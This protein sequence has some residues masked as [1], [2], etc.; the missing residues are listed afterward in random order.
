[1]KWIISFM[2]MILF[3]YGIT[4][5][6]LRADMFYG[7]QDPSQPKFGRVIDFDDREEGAVSEDDYAAQ[8]I[9]SI[10]ETELLAGADFGYYEEAKFSK[11]MCVGTGEFSERG[12]G[13]SKGWDG[14]ILIQ[15]KE[16]AS[17]VGVGIVDIDGG[18][19]TIAVYTNHDD[20][21]GENPLEIYEVPDKSRVYVVIDRL[22]T[23]DIKYLQISGDGFTIDDLQFDVYPSIAGGMRALGDVPE[24]PVTGEVYFDTVYS[25]A[26]IFN[27]MNWDEFRGPQGIQGPIGP[28]G[29]D[30]SPDTPAQVLAKISQVDG[31]GSGLDA[32]TLDG[33]DSES[34]ASSS[35]MHDDRYYTE[36]ELNTVNGGGQVNWNN[37]TD[38]PA[39]FADNTDDIGVETETD[40]VY[41]NSAASG[42][43]T[44][45]ISEWDT[46][47]GWGDHA[48]VGYLTEE[49]WMKSGSDIYY[50]DGNVGIRTNSPDS[51]LDVAGVITANTN[52]ADVAPGVG[53]TAA[54]FGVSGLISGAA[55]GNGAISGLLYSTSPAASALWGQASGGGAGLIV[56]QWGSGDI[57]RF[58]DTQS[59]VFVV[60]DG[61]NVG[62]GTAFPETRLHVFS[63]GL[64]WNLDA[65]EGDFKIGDSTHRLKIGVATGGYGAGTAGIRMQGGLGRIILGGGE[66]E[67]VSIEKTGEVGIG[68]INPNYELD[69]VGDINFTGALYQNGVL[70]SDP[71]WIFSGGDLFSGVS[72]N[73][74]VGTASPT[75][76]L[77]VF[78]PTD[79]MVGRF[80]GANTEWADLVVD[81]GA[82]VSAA[83]PSLTLQRMGSTK[84]RFYVT[85]GNDLLIEGAGDIGF[86]NTSSKIENMTIKSD[87]KVGIGTTSPVEK[88]DV[89]GGINIGTTAGTN[90]GTLR[91]TGT[92]F[93]GYDGSLWKSLT[94]GSALWTE[95]GSNI[96]YNAVNVGIGTDNPLV[97]VHIH[98]N[99][100]TF[101]LSG[102]ILLALDP[103][104]TYRDAGLILKTTRPPGRTYQIRTGIG[105][106]GSAND[107]FIID[108]TAREQGTTFIDST[109][110][111]LDTE[112]DLGIGT[113]D[114]L[115]KLDVAGTVDMDGF[116]LGSASVPGY[117]LTT[118]GG[119]VGSWQ[120][121][122]TMED[123]DDWTISGNN[124]YSAVSGNV[125]IGTTAPSRKLHVAGDA[126]IEGNLTIP[127]TSRYFSIP[128]STFR[129]W[130]SSSGYYTDINWISALSPA[131][132]VTVY[133]PV[134]VPNG[135]T[136]EELHGVIRDKGPNDITLELYVITSTGGKFRLADVT[137]SGAL[138]N[139]RSISTNLSSVVDNVNNAY[140]VV[141][142][143][144]A[145][146]FSSGADIF[147]HKVRIRYSITN[148]LP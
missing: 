50:N 19:E 113:F 139:T 42:I 49:S 78:E 51:D 111:V 63:N 80:R 20:V 15:F 105:Y 14:T 112:G 128:G 68:I 90:A 60:K 9:V 83:K 22:G 58:Q 38:V 102:D 85:S 118:S 8:G 117:V 127:E 29:A 136:L 16:Y 77:D 98:R 17:K 5:N 52:G 146:D 27:G 73:I 124:I 79:S 129:P 75:C 133:A 67:V 76:K 101:G 137:S 61:G 89:D 32:D 31:T 3:V 142:S 147:L 99:G 46:A 135:A 13:K 104:S 74:G 86:Q 7:E 21:V 148:P 55:Y 122:P 62:I 34:F 81:A 4:Y 143:W 48:A 25:M 70:F 95:N 103:V 91:W 66:K 138:T 114:P 107:L 12:D 110:V 130:I 88:L 26:Y 106:A 144:T 69:V 120:P 18:I 93:E 33:A 84:G 72:G 11:P 44:G 37:L 47:Y 94:S 140:L 141:A 30:G 24:D 40:P 39:G 57:V 119:G 109:R 126:R 131:Q 145:G 54:V 71:D 36:S 132:N 65:T 28:P 115:Y 108:D 41:H 100:G 2:S 1:M 45:D 35:H 10:T 59:D 6:V 53:G 92:D 134:H 43:S 97:P 82:A 125:G 121:P 64:H 96:Y 87:G 116:K 23:Y 56:D 123:D